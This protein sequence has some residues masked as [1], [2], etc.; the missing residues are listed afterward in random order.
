MAQGSAQAL[1]DRGNTRLYSEEDL[2]QPRRSRR[3]HDLG[4]NLAGVEIIINTA[5][6]GQMRGSPAVHRCVSTAG[7]AWRLGTASQSAMVKSA[8]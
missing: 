6:D 2:E 7:A 1:A 4:V 8:S 5:E 3:S